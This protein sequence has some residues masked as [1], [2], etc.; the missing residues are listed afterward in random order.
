MTASENPGSYREQLSAPL[1]WYLISVLFGVGLGIIFLVVGPWPALAGLAAG[2]AAGIWVVLAYGRVVIRLDGPNLQAGPASLPLASHGR[3][4][5]L[6]PEQA[7][8][9]RTQDAD[10]RAF[11]L[12]RSYIRTAVRVEVIDPRD[13]HPYLYLS[14][15]HPERLAATIAGATAGANAAAR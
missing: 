10:P 11:M 8:A 2:S 14:S 15:R 1:S 6:D 12:L 3:A 7:R 4:R 5:A 9:L 13:P